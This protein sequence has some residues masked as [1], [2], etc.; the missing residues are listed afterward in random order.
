MDRIDWQA[1]FGALY[2]GFFDL[3]SIRALPQDRLWDEM[4]LRLS[5]FSPDAADIPVP[6][7]TA[8]GFYRGDLETL[9]RA[10]RR[11][12]ESWPELYRAETRVY[13]GFVGGEIASFCMLE[14]MGVCDGVRFAGPGCVGTLPERRRQGIGLK[15]VQNATAILKAEGYDY[16]YIHYTGV[17][18]WY[19]RL[20]YRTVLRWNGGGL[21]GGR[22]D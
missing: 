16:S 4:A 3:P 12:D 1:V 11:V 2:P 9:R 10:V 15:M 21:A 13:C 20:G 22:D 19:A 14:D 17:A 6:D 18:P 5:G 8:F 7:G